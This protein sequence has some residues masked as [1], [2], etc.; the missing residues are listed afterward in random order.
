MV[1]KLFTR[2]KSGNAL[3]AIW[4]RSMSLL[5][6]LVFS[7]YHSLAQ[8]AGFSIPDTVCEDNPVFI[9]G[10]TPP[11]A[12]SYRW[13]FCT[14]NASYEPDGINMGNPNQILNAPRY[15]TL[16][17]DSLQ[18]YTFTTSTGTA[19]VLRCHYGTSL[20]QNPVAIANLGSFGVLTNQVTGIQVKKDNG[21]WY[22]FVANGNKMLRLVFGNSLLNTPSGQVFDLPGVVSASG[23]ALTRQGT[24]WI[25]FC[26]DIAGSS[27]FRLGF[28]NSLGVDP[29]VTM[30]GS[31]GQLNAPAGIVIAEEDDQWYA[32]ICNAGNSTI[33]RAGFGISLMNPSPSMVILA[34][35]EG[36]NLNT[37]ITLIND[38]GGINGFVTNCIQES[39]L[40]VVHLVFTAGLGGPVTG[41]HI[42][43]NGILNK[44][45]GISQ[46]VRQG[47]T[48]YAYVANFGSSS[49]TR[50]YFPSC[51]GASQPFYN[52]PDPPPITYPE[53]GEYNIL[54]TVNAGSPSESSLCRNL[55]VMPKP[56]L[57]LGPDR[58]ICQGTGNILDAGPGNSLYQWSTGATTQTIAVDTSGTYRVH[59]VNHW[60]CEAFDT[61]VMTVNSAA[62]SYV[63]TT[64]CEGLSY[65]AQHAFRTSGGIYLDTLKMATGCDS[66]VTTDLHFK[67]CPLQIWFPNAFSPDG[68]GLND[69]FRPVGSNI[70]NYRL[71]IFNRWG[72]LIFESS[73]ILTG[74]DGMVKGKMAAPGVYTFDATFESTQ[75]PGIIRHEKGTVT[76]AR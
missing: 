58:T 7:G 4:P 31:A 66:I 35:I 21:T 72:A 61:I 14:G 62:E 19:S 47:D 56:S 69:L 53:P 26:T 74:W 12:S 18:Y 50:M 60:G 15:I 48:L 34:G 25:G 64:V 37:D 2:K 57:S 43:N 17:K 44:P 67:E 5:L 71:L 20:T 76:L 1:K 45:Y 24:E 33:T 30:L 38:C 36:L 13:S 28:G 55:I 54:L 68:D 63:D 3:K 6:V 10:V 70:T 42:E 75:Y 65:W 27:L 22:G 52:G 23:L 41:Y 8:N 32:F 9:T 29:V 11:S 51:S 59:A 49:L 39:D 16:V 73:D 46:V 40:C